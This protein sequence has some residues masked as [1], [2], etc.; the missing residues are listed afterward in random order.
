MSDKHQK[1]PLNSKLSTE[2]ET[3]GSSKKGKY[4]IRT[5]FY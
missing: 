2:L 5:F 4:K 3:D 1:N